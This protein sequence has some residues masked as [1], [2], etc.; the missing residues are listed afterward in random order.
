[1]VRL[2]G[3]LRRTANPSPSPIPRDVDALIEVL[4]AS[5]SRQAAEQ[6]LLEADGS[7][8]AAVDAFY[9]QQAASTSNAAARAG[10][11]AAQDRE[12]IVIGG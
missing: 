11:S 8:E 2:L 12:V 10:P 5:V 4:G 1:M 6:L 7:V 3:S 9:E